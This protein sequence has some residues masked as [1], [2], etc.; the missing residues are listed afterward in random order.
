MG[1]SDVSARVSSSPSKRGTDRFVSQTVS[2]MIFDDHRTTSLVYLNDG[3][4]LVFRF[5]GL[6]GD[7]VVA[8]FHRCAADLGIFE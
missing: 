3:I 2:S 5:V 8:P 7:G 1:G 6:F 4:S